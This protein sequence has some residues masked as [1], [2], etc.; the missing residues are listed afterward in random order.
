MLI[1]S[2]IVAERS[3]QDYLLGLNWDGYE[4]AV[5]A[6]VMYDDAPWQ[7]VQNVPVEER[8]LLGLLEEHAEI[9]CDDA[10]VDGLTTYNRFDALVGGVRYVDPYMSDGIAAEP[11][12]YH[13]SEFGDSLWYLTNYLR[14]F[15]IH[16]QDALEDYADVVDLETVASAPLSSREAQ[17]YVEHPD[18]LKR[19]R[20]GASRLF[21]TAGGVFHR[22]SRTTGIST[23]DK[24]ALKYAAA[25]YLLAMEDLARATFGKSIAEIMEA[26]VQKINGRVRRPTVV[27]GN[28]DGR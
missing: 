10:P 2:E 11:V 15:D 19:F 26:N 12:E 17:T 28:G 22:E 13:L 5:A 18:E 25:A 6:Q 7:T 9:M 23:E 3:V 27:R 8:M 20:T 16:M 1:M 24:E 21:E 4:S 14:L